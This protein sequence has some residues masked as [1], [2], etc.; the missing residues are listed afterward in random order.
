LGLDFVVSQQG[1]DLPWLVVIAQRPE[2]STKVA[3]DLRLLRLEIQKPPPAEGE[4]TSRTKKE[5]SPDVCEFPK[6]DR[7]SAPDAELLVELEPGLLLAQ[8][9]D[10]RLIC[11]PEWLVPG[12]VVTPKFGWAP[13]TR[14]TWEKGKRVEVPVPPSE[15]FVATATSEAGEPLA[16]VKELVG[17]PFTLDASYAP[18]S[19]PPADPE[20]PPPLE[21]EVKPLGTVSEPRDAN[22]DIAIKNP[23]RVGRHLF[24]RREFVTYEVIGPAGTATCNVY[25]DER[26]PTRQAFDF[27]P[28]GGTMRVA[29]RLAEMCP[30]GTFGPPGLY[31]IHARLDATESGQSHGLDAFVGVVTTREPAL[32]RMPGGKPE[33]MWLLS[34]RPPGT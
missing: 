32:L 18:V 34:V 12:A 6:A 7:P 15:P 4:A 21:L 28:A 24:F 27:I 22:I 25:P 2:T 20:G 16:P 19:P 23:A 13:A 5:T 9:F 30:Q 14:V 1:A 26:A 11:A 31:K 8:S 29:S 10:P 17:E 3:A 33:P